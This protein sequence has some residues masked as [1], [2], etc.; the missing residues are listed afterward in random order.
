[1]GFEWQIY[2]ENINI[3]DVIIFL[4]QVLTHGIVE[5]LHCTPE[6]NITPYVNW[7]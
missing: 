3:S 6:L 1:M 5:S 7:K 4:F 2:L